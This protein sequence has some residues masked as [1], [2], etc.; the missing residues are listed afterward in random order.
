MHKKLYHRYFLLTVLICV[1]IAGCKK[2]GNP[3]KND[4]PKAKLTLT[5]GN[6]QSGI[7]GQDL[8]DSLVI[9][10]VPPAGLK[11]SQYTIKF[12][13]VQGNGLIESANSNNFLINPPDINGLVQIKWRLGCNN[14]NQKVTLYLYADSTFNYNTGLPTGLPDDSL[15]ISASGT[16]P[17]GWGRACGCG[18]PTYN[19]KITSFDKKTLYM[20]NNG[21]YSS[22]DGGINWYKVTGMPYWATIMDVQFNSQGWM[23]VLTANNG[24]YYTKDKVTWQAINNGLLDT[25]TPTSFLVTDDALFVSFYF[26][27]PYI[28]T[29]NGGF[30]QLVLVGF[31]S[32]RFYLITH[33]SGGYIYLFN[34]WGNL[35]VS[36]DV[37][38]TWQEIPLPSQYVNYQAYD[39]EIGPDGNLYIGSDQATI[40]IVS[41]TTGQGSYRS[42]YQYNASDQPANNIQFFNNNIYFLLNDNPQPGIYNINNNWGKV[43]LGFTQAINS[44]Y[45]RQEGTFLLFSTDG[46]YYNN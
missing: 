37:G 2:D 30:W 29:N 28:T 31:G 8:H 39:L 25:R 20:A 36:K 34:D 5:Y 10:I 45:I 22:T 12:N 40:A 16:K 17:S 1:L 27:G 11:A 9:K 23:Y 18:A 32:Q 38:K 24:I 7:Y 43:D 6:G 33:K 15:T 13:M 19:S 21:L 35:I 41:P 14:P 42:F 3:V 44:Y 26:D 46:F 4:G